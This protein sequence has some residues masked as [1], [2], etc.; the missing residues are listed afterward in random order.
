MS[1]IESHELPTRQRLVNGYRDLKTAELDGVDPDALVT[2]TLGFMLAL[3]RHRE[4]SW[5]DELAKA[6]ITGTSSIDA[7]VRL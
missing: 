4:V 7:S 6:A 5:R 3:R 2:T 1:T